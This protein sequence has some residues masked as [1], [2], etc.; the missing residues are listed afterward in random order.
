MSGNER[1]TLTKLIA[2]ADYF[3]VSL[4]YLTVGQIIQEIN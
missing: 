3:N 4:D 2:L 1:T